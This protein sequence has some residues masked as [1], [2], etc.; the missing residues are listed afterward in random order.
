MVQ[1]DVWVFSQ[2]IKPLT[3]SQMQTLHLVVFAWLDS[4]DFGSQRKQ[5]VIEMASSLA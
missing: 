3:N 5:Y 2:V 4:W 1:T